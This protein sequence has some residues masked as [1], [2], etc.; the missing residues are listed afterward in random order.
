[1]DSSFPRGR[2]LDLS[3]P[4]AVVI[5]ILAHAAQTPLIPVAREMNLAKT[6]AAR[7]LGA[8]RPSWTTLFI[9]AFGLLSRRRAELRRSFMRWPRPHL[10]EH[11]ESVCA[12]AVE[13]EYDGELAVFFG[14]IVAPEGRTLSAIQQAIRTYKERPVQEIGRFRRQI[15]LGRAPGIVRRAVVWS[16]LHA[17]GRQRIYRFGTFGVTNYG[18]WGA[19]S[20]RPISPTATILS[21]GPISDHGKAVVKV[22]YDHRVLDGAVV[23]R[24]LSELEEILNTEIIGELERC[25]GE[26]TSVPVSARAA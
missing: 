11:P 20:L 16:A 14:Q 3:P 1:M 4:R 24:C 25:P 17:S 7:R 10:Y 2:R 18:Q 23:A 21:L 26:R 6:A 19:E 12:L 15:R 5:E 22:V 8:E 13:R 9:R